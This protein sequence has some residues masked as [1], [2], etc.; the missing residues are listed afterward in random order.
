MRRGIFRW[1]AI[2]F[3]VTKTLDDRTI[4]MATCMKQMLD[5]LLHMWLADH[6]ALPEIMQSLSE[7]SDTRRVVNIA[8]A[9]PV[10][11]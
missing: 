7:G 1:N 2:K 3:K 9:M 4:P 10:F 5:A 6:A 8:E 11:D